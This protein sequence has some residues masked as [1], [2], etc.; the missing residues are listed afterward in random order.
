MK[1]TENP[2]FLDKVVPS[3]EKYRLEFGGQKK[4]SRITINELCNFIETMNNTRCLVGNGIIYSPS[5]H[6]SDDL[7]R[8]LLVKRGSYYLDEQD[9]GFLNRFESHFV[10]TLQMCDQKKSCFEYLS[11]EE[12]DKRTLERMQIYH[13]IGF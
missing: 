12:R 5:N 13:L 8:H 6:R 7:S 1:I 3:I 10:Y 11:K 2:I 4:S 9:E